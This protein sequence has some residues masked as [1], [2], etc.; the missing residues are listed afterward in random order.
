[1]AASLGLSD[2]QLR[3][4]LKQ[5]E[6]AAYLQIEVRKGRSRTNIYRAT[7]PDG[8]AEVSEKRTSMNRSN[9]RKAD[10]RVLS[11][12]KKPD[13]HVTKTGHGRPT[14]PL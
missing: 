12:A 5:L 14:I 2:R 6:T 10:T 7:L 4:L 3:R 9:G 13:T 1:M 8:A 11:T